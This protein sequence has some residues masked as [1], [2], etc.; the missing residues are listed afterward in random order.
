MSTIN[1]CAT[2]GG[3]IARRTNVAYSHDEQPN[4]GPWLHLH[5]E[6]WQDNVHE[7]KPVEVDA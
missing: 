5:A 1:T 3:P 7:A 4:D 2:C 6:D